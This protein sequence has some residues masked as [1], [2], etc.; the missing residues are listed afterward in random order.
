MDI[1][2]FRLT[3][4]G[5]RAVAEGR[6]EVLYK[7]E[8]GRGEARSDYIRNDVTWRLKRTRSAGR[9]PKKCTS[10]EAELKKRSRLDLLCRVDERPIRAPDTAVQPKRIDNHADELW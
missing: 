10:K 3:V 8:V 6:M 7:L 2:E 5:D 1:T 9:S 4:S